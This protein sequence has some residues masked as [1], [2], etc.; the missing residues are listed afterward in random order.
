MLKRTITFIKDY[1]YPLALF[2]IS[3]MLIFSAIQISFW[4]FPS[5][6]GRSYGDIFPANM[7]L[8][9]LFQWDAFYYR[10]MAQEGYKIFP[11]NIFSNIAFMPGYPLMLRLIDMFVNNIYWSGVLVSNMAFLLS[12]AILYKLIILLKG[13]QI[14]QISLALLAF[15][16]FSMFFSSMY[17]ESLFL[18]F[19]VLSFYYFYKEKWLWAGFFAS[20]AGVTKEMGLTISVIQLIFFF[21]QRQRKS[22]HRADYTG[23]IS[24]TSGFIGPLILLSYL[25]FHF[26]SPMVFITSHMAFGNLF[27]NGYQAMTDSLNKFIKYQ[28]VYYLFPVGLKLLHLSIGI[29]SVVSLLKSKIYSPLKYWGLVSILMIFFVWPSL[30]RLVLTVIPVYVCWGIYLKE[31]QRYM[32]AVFF[33]ELMLMFLISVFLSHSFWVG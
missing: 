15:Q 17:A 24:L 14:A 23:F 29:L 2:I 7:V 8:N 11:G 6:R 21:L 3:R 22:F 18:L 31:H 30:G 28:E 9:G 33:G 26:G 12:L 25:W 32:K 20:L 4:L 1:K 5:F 13:K 16:P 27:V 19:A 10:I